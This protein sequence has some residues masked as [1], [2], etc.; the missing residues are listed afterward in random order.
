MTSVLSEITTPT[1]PFN[2]PTEAEQTIAPSAMKL[3]VPKEL[4][5]SAPV[6]VPAPV[7]TK[8]AA[9]LAGLSESK[10]SN[11]DLETLIKGLQESKGIENELFAWMKQKTAS[12]VKSNGRR[13]EREES[14]EDVEEVESDSDELES[15]DCGGKSD[16]RMERE[17]LEYESYEE[18]GDMK[19]S[20]SDEAGSGNLPEEQPDLQSQK[21]KLHNDTRKVSWASTED[22]VLGLACGL[23]P[24]WDAIAL[25]L[26]HRSKTACRSRMDV[27]TNNNTLVQLHSSVDQ[28]IMHGIKSALRQS[29]K[30]SRNLRGSVANE[31]DIL[32]TVSSLL[33]TCRNYFQENQNGENDGSSSMDD[34]HELPL[35][36]W[37]KKEAKARGEIQ[38]PPGPKHAVNKMQ[39]TSKP[40]SATAKPGKRGAARKPKTNIG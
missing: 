3:D 36:K 35:P 30:Q 11:G 18:D 16:E 40:T 39:S 13:E 9:G 5:K 23:L 24:N 22:F 12:M 25:C 10:V 20:E 19:V 21:P 32:E 38:K 15:G 26:P 31:E 17:V 1:T 2:M 8:Y 6:Q 7:Q 37:R 4:H 33:A 34:T 27:L 14:D 28:S 29:A